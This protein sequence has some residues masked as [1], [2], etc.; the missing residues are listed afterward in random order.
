MLQV[1]LDTAE[2]AGKERRRSGL[3]RHVGPEASYLESMRSLQLDEGMDTVLVGSS[4]FWYAASP[5]PCRGCCSVWSLVMHT[6][7]C[8]KPEY[9]C[10]LYQDMVCTAC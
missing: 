3:G 4:G 1:A 9:V 2:G 10:H 6:V 5:G 7:Q 8:V